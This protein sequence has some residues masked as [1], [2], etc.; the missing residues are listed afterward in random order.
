MTDHTL[1]LMEY[2]AA[3]ENLLCAWRAV[4]GNIP[5]RRR[6]R[7]AGPDG[8]SLLEFERDLP[9]QLE[10]L[11]QALLSGRYQPDTP[12]RRQIPKPGGGERT[13]CVLTVRE[14]VAQRAAQQTLEPLWEPEFLDC[15]FGFR[16]GRSIAA[17]AGRAR[18]LRQRGLGWVVDGDIAACFD[19]LNHD[20]LAA[21][22]R[23][24]VHSERTVHL[25]QN[26][27]DAGVVQA[28][29]PHEPPP[30]LARRMQGAASTLERGMSW[31]LDGLDSP[32][33]PYQAPTPYSAAGLGGMNDPYAPGPGSLG[34]MD[35]PYAADRYQANETG[36][37]QLALSKTPLRDALVSDWRRQTLQ[38]LAAGGLMFGAS[39]AGPALSGLGRKLASPSGRRLVQ[40]GALTTGGLAGAA[41]AAAAASFLLYRRAGPTPAGVLQGSP[42]SPLLANIYLHPFDQAL[43]RQRLHLVRYADDWVILCADQAAAESAFNQALRTLARLR[44]KINPDK[45]CI[46]SPGE[47][48]SWLGETL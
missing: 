12:A 31:I 43:S 46:L 44:L 30:E 17:A 36:A 3:P 24:K 11:R 37:A 39:W 9:A 45:T 20:L 10:A 5:Q 25:L 15:S 38:R 19:S 32:A 26:W 40:R 8:I 41:V 2:I 34:G 22:L 33:Y 21:L 16:P 23:R 35:D 6:A 42:L 48:L 14:R 7:S 4:R 18:G 27:L 29:P 13:I 28:G 47:K 1:D